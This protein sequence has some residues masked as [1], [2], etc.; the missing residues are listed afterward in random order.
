MQL[1]AIAQIVG[2]EITFM[3]APPSAG[4]RIAVD[5]DFKMG[6]WIEMSSTR[7]EIRRTRRAS[8]KSELAGIKMR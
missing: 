6:C 1:L 5:R 4:Q 2:Q 7:A 8:R 3:C